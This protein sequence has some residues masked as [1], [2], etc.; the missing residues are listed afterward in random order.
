MTR[1]TRT[2]IIDVLSRNDSIRDVSRRTYINVLNRISE[3]CFGWYG[4]CPYD[5]DKLLERLAADT[6]NRHTLR[7]R[8][9]ILAILVRQMTPSERTAYFSTSAGDV[10]EKVSAVVRSVGNDVHNTYV[11]QKMT[12]TEKE[13][14]EQWPVVERVWT[15][16]MPFPKLPK[17]FDSRVLYKVQEYALAGLYTVLPPVRNDYRTVRVNEVP[18]GNYITID[19][20][21]HIATIVL[22]EY[23]TSKKYGSIKLH[24]TANQNAKHKLLY[25]ALKDLCNARKR[26]GDDFLF[27]PQRGGRDS[28]TSPN[29]SQF[30]TAIYQQY[31]G[32]PLGSQMIRKIY[33]SY[34]QKD[35]PS[36]VEKQNTAAAMGHS[37]N[38]QSL[39]RRL[40]AD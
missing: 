8:Y 19:T 25:E 5:I 36:L 33:L 34:L 10:L 18:G 37:T 39:Y 27:A 6:A 31:L 15:K 12:V 3:L 20:S 38:M 14:W 7:L 9:S 24:V 17:D 2:L 30:L 1:L 40:P 13:K 28:L 11:Q 32:K 23:K 22:S 4:E 21:K 16:K 26:I 29:Y 35:E